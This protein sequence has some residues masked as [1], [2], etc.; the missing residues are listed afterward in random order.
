MLNVG[1]S[2]KNEAI[3][4]LSDWYKSIY[5]TESVHTA[6]YIALNEN[7]NIL[8]R[9]FLCPGACDSCKIESVNETLFSE[10]PK[11]DT[12]VLD[13]GFLK[14]TTWL[15]RLVVSIFPENGE[16]FNFSRQ[17]QAFPGISREI[18]VPYNPSFEQLSPFQ[19]PSHTISDPN[20]TC[21][22]T[23]CYFILRHLRNMEL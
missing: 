1:I 6:Y 10:Q 16:F 17:Y 14:A 9:I 18:S 22:A 19:L 21:T 5:T 23:D 15:L 4:I 20:E 2:Y 7:R 3:P 8:W 13:R 11:W 12:P